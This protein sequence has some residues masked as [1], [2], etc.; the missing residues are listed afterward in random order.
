MF[1]HKDAAG[2]VFSMYNLPRKLQELLHM[3][4]CLPPFSFFT[5]PH[6]CVITV[7]SVADIFNSKPRKLNLYISV[8]SKVD[9]P[10]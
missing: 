3:D 2:L 1:E 10:H 6:M 5:L 7:H 4:T 9:S 8:Y